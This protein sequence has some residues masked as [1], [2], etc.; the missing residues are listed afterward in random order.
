MKILKVSLCNIHSLKGKHE[1]DFAN[2]L[3]G[4]VG[5]YAITGNT[6]A[7]KSTILDAIT[8][9]LYGQTNRHGNK[10]LDQEIITRNE[11]EAYSEVTFEVHNQQYFAEWKVSFKRNNKINDSKIRLSKIIENDKQLLTDKKTESKNKIEELIGL[12]FHQFTKSVLL[13]QNNFSAFLKAKPGERAE[14]LSKITGTEIYEYIS[15]AVFEKT[16]ALEDTLT[17]SKSLLNNNLLT[18]EEVAI[19][20]ETVETKS[21][22]TADIATALTKIIAELKWYDD[23][24]K[25]EVEYT[26]H[27]QELTA[28]EK[29]IQEQKDDYNKLEKYNKA[30]LLE[31]DLIAFENADSQYNATK[32]KLLKVENEIVLAN[33]LLKELVLDLETKYS[34]QTIAKEELDTSLPLVEKAK[35]KLQDQMSQEKLIAELDKEMEV[36]KDQLEEKQSQNIRLVAEKEILANLISNLEIEVAAHKKYEHWVEDKKA[37]GIIYKEIEKLEKENATINSDTLEQDIALYRN[38]INKNIEDITNLTSKLAT[39]EP[40][41]NSLVQERNKLKSATI[42]TTEKEIAQAKLSQWNLLQNELSKLAEIEAKL[43]PCKQRITELLC[44]EKLANEK[45]RSQ[46]KHIE[47]LVENL[48][49]Q[50]T[51]AS[52][53]EHRT[54]LKDG[55]ACPLC[56][57]KEHPY[58]VEKLDLKPSEAEQRLADEKTNL[59]KINKEI[60]TIAKEKIQLEGTVKSYEENVQNA[61]IEIKKS[62][63]FLQIPEP[64]AQEQLIK[65]AQNLKQLIDSYS[66]DLTRSTALTADIE[67]SALDIQLQ[68]DGLQKLEIAKLETENQLKSW[69]QTANSNEQLLAKNNA[70]IVAKYEEFQSIINNYDEKITTNE[71][72]K[73][74]EIGK[75]LTAKHDKWKMANEELIA[76]KE[77]ERTIDTDIKNLAFALNL[78]EK[79]HLQLLEKQN[80]ENNLRIETKATIALLTANFKLKNPRE[81]EDRLRENVTTISK[82]INEANNK[83][84]GY[85]ASIAENLKVKEELWKA[86]IIEEASVANNALKLKK[87]LQ[88]NEF[89]SINSLKNDLQLLNHA[90]IAANKVKNENDRISLKSLRDASSDKLLSLQKLQLTSLSVELLEAQ[91]IELTTKNQELNQQIGGAK[92]QLNNNEKEIAANQNLLAKIENQEQICSQWKQLNQLIGSSDGDRF[93]KFAQDFTL[94][95]LVQYANRHLAVMYNRYELHK[96]DLA[97]EM[98]L[99]IK[100]KH[101]FEQIRTINSLSGGETFLVSLALALGLSDLAS[102]NTKIRSLFIDEGFGSLDPESLNNALDA[103]ELLQQTDDRQIGIISHVEELKKRIHTQIKVTKTSAEYSKIEVCDS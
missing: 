42:L 1:I 9:A 73:F 78:I 99:Q 37:V 98:E 79:E 62:L 95:L 70:S 3:L 45:L 29:I 39:E 61:E 36:K 76:Q 86:K 4:S 65:N 100:D 51:I 87:L 81:E 25:T 41:Y 72:A 97:A 16:K 27:R 10:S 6:G 20:K 34:Q 59:E 49:L 96:D 47:A 35:E 14:M 102:K 11:K 31:K 66:H 12:S 64:P 2:G 43:T 58:A 103:L 40:K 52:L 88:E 46:N 22:Q 83:K 48:M 71:I 21:A 60:N 28:I 74:I 94:S 53:E 24:D 89:E 44:Q 80:T 19:L 63:A 56:G 26:K 32:E 50:K 92:E 84:A 33:T 75:K 55:E 68:K 7:G 13:A 82:I 85:E 15:K 69:Q 38:K 23:L 17:A 93:K 57:A 91:K 18:E 77:K 30:K 5:L 67:K 101:F 90:I 8:L 54:N